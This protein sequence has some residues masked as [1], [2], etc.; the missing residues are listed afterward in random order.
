M[1]AE[2]F[3]D[4]ADKV[5]V[6]SESFDAIETLALAIGARNGRSPRA[7]AAVSLEIGRLLGFTAEELTNLR[8]AA[9]LHDVGELAEPCCCSPSGPE[10]PRVR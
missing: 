10:T 6:C 7:V 8:L 9:L 2:I 4:G 5:G 3:G 1:N